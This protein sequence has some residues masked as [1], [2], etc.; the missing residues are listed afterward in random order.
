M[1]CEMGGTGVPEWWHG[2]ESIEKEDNMT[3]QEKFIESVN[4]VLREV[5][6][7]QLDLSCNGENRKYA[8]KVLG[9]MHEAF[10]DAYGCNYLE[11]GQHEFVELPAVI[12]GRN[13][14]HIAL[15]IVTIDMQASGEHWGTF[16]LTP[17]GVL[18]QG[19][20]S[21]TETERN[22][23]RENFACYD[24]WYTP[25]VEGDIHRKCEDIPESVQSLLQS[26][27]PEQNEQPED[28]IEMNL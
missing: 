5:D 17:Q 16:F 12:C 26:C 24:Y 9:Q 19:S 10:I 11:R 13:S 14:S 3:E 4:K 25:I 18:D 22:Y 23:L 7:E 28:S 6:Y 20:K 8:K 21:L 27:L 15:G 2:D 1:E